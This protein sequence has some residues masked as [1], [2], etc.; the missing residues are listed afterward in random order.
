MASVAVS[1]RVERVK[2]IIPIAPSAWT[3]ANVQ[4][5]PEFIMQKPWQPFGKDIN[6]LGGKWN[7]QNLDFTKSHFILDEMQVD[8]NM[9]G[10]LVLH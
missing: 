6:K 2:D 8:F 7:M 1:L 5:G 3:W 10:S 4:A 9:F